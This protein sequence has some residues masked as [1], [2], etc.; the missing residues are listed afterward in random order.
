M[1]KRK[2]WTDA[3]LW[4]LIAWYPDTH[5]RTL[6]RRFGRSRHSIYNAVHF[7]GLLKDPDFLLNQNREL[8]RR[9]DTFGAP[10]RFLKGYLPANKGLR[11]PG[12][13]AGRMRETQFKKGHFP[14][15]RDPDFYVLGA[16]RVNADGYIDMRMSFEAG[17]KGWRALHRILWEDAHGPV[18][19]GCIVRFKDRDKLNVELG[20]LE[21]ISRADNMRLNSIHKLPPPLKS[22]IRVLGALKRTLNRRTRDEEHRRPA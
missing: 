7:L 14:Y 2:I 18:S 8:G 10:H 15:N 5:I 1:G 3:D 17:S 22:T 16:L 11:Q 12:W 4:R 13:F 6:C 9:L 20:N 19:P 21:L